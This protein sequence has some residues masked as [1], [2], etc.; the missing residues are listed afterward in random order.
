MSNL[1]GVKIY[2]QFISRHTTSEDN[3][4][5]SSMLFKLPNKPETM[6]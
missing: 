2:K 3:S 4:M 5:S 6:R 1:E